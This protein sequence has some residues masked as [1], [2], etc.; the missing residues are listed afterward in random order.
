[1]IKLPKEVTAMRTVQTFL[2]VGSCSETLSNVLNRAYDHPLYHEEH[3]TL[4]FA[5]G[6]LQHGKQCGALWGS[7]L[8]AGSQAY[9]I[10][11]EGTRAETAS[12]LAAQELVAAFERDNSVLNCIDLIQADWNKPGQVVRYFLRGGFFKCYGMTARFSGIAYQQINATLEKE[13]DH[14]PEGPVSCSTVVARRF[15]VPDLHAVTVAGLAG[16]IGLCGG[17]C[18]ALATAIWI[19]SM[20]K[21]RA[22]D[23]K[24]EI[25]SAKAQ[26]LIARF[27]QKTGGEMECSAICGKTFQTIDEHAAHLREGGCSELIELLVEA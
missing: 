18:G 24:V 12:I 5:G 3:A 7:V 8:G 22:T 14:V 1:M 9:H 10:Y 13:P 25:K 20:N 15:G 2:K 11:G 19:I 23:G 21:S 6:I 27:L 17:G 26:E 4:P 16:G